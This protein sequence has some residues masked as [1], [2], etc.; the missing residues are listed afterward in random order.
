MHQAD[1]EDA[2]QFFDAE[3]LGKIQSIEISVPSKDSALTKKSRGIGRRA[4]RQAKRY[5]RAS[6]A[7]SLRIGDPIKLQSRNR[8]QALNQSRYQRSFVRDRRSV[9][10]HQSFAP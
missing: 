9:R 3:T 7:K 2:T 8:Q 4:F 6:L 1:A 5:C 10:G